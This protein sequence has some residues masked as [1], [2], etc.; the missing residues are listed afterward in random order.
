MNFKGQVAIV[1]GG[2]NGIGKT[3]SIAF[4]GAGAKVVVVDRDGSAAKAVAD[5]IRANGGDAQ[6]VTADVT[7]SGDVQGYVSAALSAFGRIDCLFNNA[8]I[9]GRIAPIVDYDEAL[10]DQL[11]AINIKGVFLGL[12]YVL[13]VM[14]AQ[15]KGAIVNTSSVAGLVGTP[16]LAPY[17]ASKHAVIGMTKSAAGEVA[18]LGVRVNAVCPGPVDT[19]MIHSLEAQIDPANPQGV[20]QRYASAIPLG[21][22]A[23]TEEIANMVLF[24]C[25]DLVAGMT[26]AQVVVDGGRTA[27]GG[28]VTSVVKKA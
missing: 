19:R 11:I 4:A 16:S 13:P 14:I 17:V 20:G 23:T 3:V 18:R 5:Q 8:G 15:G 7:K 1:T 9:E 12:K 25:S 2:G 21:R 10:F 22:Y 6:A 26:G 28:A 24:L 27:C